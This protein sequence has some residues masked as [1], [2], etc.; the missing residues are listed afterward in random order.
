LKFTADEIDYSDILFQYIANGITSIYVMSAF[1]EHIALRDS[2]KDHKILGPELIL[3]RLID[4]AGMAW[5]PPITTWVNNPEEAK[6]AVIESHRT[7]YDRIKAYS[8]LSK[9]SYDAILQTADSLNMPV[10]GHIPMST[11]VEYLA[12]S[13]QGMISHAEEILKF[14]AD[15]KPETIDS[16]AKTLVDNSVWVTAT[17][18]TTRNLIELFKNPEEQISMPR[19]E[20]LHP[21][22]HGVWNYINENL[23][24]PIPLQHKQYIE[25]SLTSFQLPFVYSFHSQGG[26][27]LAGSDALVPPT[28]PGIS[29]H[30]ELQELVNAGLTPYESLKTSTSN[31]SKFLGT[32]SS[33]GTIDPGKKANLVLLNGNPLEEISNT[34][35][36]EGVLTQNQWISADNINERMIQISDSYSSL[37]SKKTQ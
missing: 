12:T 4:G 15:H 6:A 21:Q 26:G 2:I 11:S 28:L 27:L 3:S 13:G 8:F 32:L 37:L 14:A 7:G 33:T 34:K 9:E 20:Y 24:E 25:E 35:E 29:L 31:A 23:Y 16:L 36:I 30:A 17:L 5:P 19:T 22:M 10:D 1:P 18:T